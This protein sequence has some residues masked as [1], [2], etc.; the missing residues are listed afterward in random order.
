[1]N[2]RTRSRS[3]RQ[4]WGNIRDYSLLTALAVAFIA[5]VYYLIIGSFKPT[6]EVLSGF[7]G[8][9][10]RNLSLDN[11]RSVFDALSSDSTGYFFGFMLN[12]V[13]VSSVIVFL[14]LLINSMAAYAFASLHWQA[15]DK[16]FLIVVALVIVPFEAVAIPLVFMFNDQRNTLLIQILPFIANAFSIYLFYTFFLAF[17][18]SIQEAA[19]MDGLGAFGTFFRIVIPNSKPVIATVA[20]LTFLASWGQFLWPSLVISDPLFR[21]LPLQISVF[22]GQRPT[23]WGAVFAFGVLLILPVLLFFL[24]F[25]RYFVQSVAGSSVKG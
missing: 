23:D 13:I 14:G 22:S 6:Q 24:I 10:P 16:L 4:R 9:L 7:E 1:M 25:Q 20:I 19:R 5:P 21:T 3:A 15:R 12:S 2:V 18:R 8:F 11:Y 17:P